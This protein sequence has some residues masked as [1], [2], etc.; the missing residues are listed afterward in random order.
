MK[1]IRVANLLMEALESSR[2]PPLTSTAVLGPD[3]T[4]PDVK[5]TVALV[6]HAMKRAHRSKLRLTQAYD[7]DVRPLWARDF[8][9]LAEPELFW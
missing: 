6:D 8:L 4:S 1:A 3:V 2:V 9:A 5:R 7:V